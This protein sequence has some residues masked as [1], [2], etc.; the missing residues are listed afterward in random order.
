VFV[1][2]RSAKFCL[3]KPLV[4]EQLLQQ[5]FIAGYS[6]MS[7][8]TYLSTKDTFCFVKRR[9]Y[10]IPLGMPVCQ[11]NRGQTGIFFALI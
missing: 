7:F 8:F 5:N 11:E 1:F 9:E 4:I 2:Q 6:A 10:T 3:E